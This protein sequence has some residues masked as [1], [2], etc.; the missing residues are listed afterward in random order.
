MIILSLAIKAAIE[1]EA[2]EFDFLHDDEEYKYLWSHGER[3]LIR[4]EIFPSMHPGSI[5]QKAVSVKHH[6]ARAARRYVPR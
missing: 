4:L 3:E 2:V 6:L 1:D 5:Y